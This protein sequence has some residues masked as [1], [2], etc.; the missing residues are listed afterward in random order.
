MEEKGVIIRSQIGPEQRKSGGLE[1]QAFFI[2]F[3]KKKFILAC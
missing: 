2:S 1:A 3:L